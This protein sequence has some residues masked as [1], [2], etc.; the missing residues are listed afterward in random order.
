MGRGRVKASPRK[1]ISL[2][3]GQIN[4]SLNT[5]F[6]APRS[7]VV[8]FNPVESEARPDRRSARRAVRRHAIESMLAAAAC[9]NAKKLKAI[10]V[11]ARLNTQ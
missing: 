4:T 9:K 7:E 1:R 11:E 8:R 10:A 3:R 2:L 6:F 5:Y